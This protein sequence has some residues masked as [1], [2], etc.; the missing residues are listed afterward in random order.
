MVALDV[1]RPENEDDPFGGVC[2]S[3]KVDTSNW[4]T[5]SPLENLKRGMTPQLPVNIQGSK[6]KTIMKEENFS[7]V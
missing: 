7:T 4:L 5:E 2:S 1:H 6:M 3:S